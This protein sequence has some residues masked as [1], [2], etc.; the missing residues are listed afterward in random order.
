ML[1]DSVVVCII[2]IV[3]KINIFFYILKI[4][5]FNVCFIVIVEIYE[6]FL[7]LIILVC[8]NK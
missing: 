1:L 6:G 8:G 7:I 5:D 3:N 2:F 4:R